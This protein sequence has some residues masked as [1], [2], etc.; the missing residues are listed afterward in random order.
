MNQD[1][2]DQEEEPDLLALTDLLE[3]RVHKDHRAVRDLEVQEDN[4][5]KED[6]LENKDLLET[7]VYKVSRYN[8]DIQSLKLHGNY[9]AY[10]EP[11]I[12]QG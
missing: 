7:R 3:S 10:R 6:Q 2:K 1:Y 8:Y 11:N 12:S 9:K 4:E 5:E